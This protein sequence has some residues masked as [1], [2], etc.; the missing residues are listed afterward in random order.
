MRQEKQI[1]AETRLIRLS[2]WL[3]RQPLDPQFN[4]KMEAAEAFKKR[5]AA[6]VSSENAGEVAPTFHQATTV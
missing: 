2:W 3:R 1:T 4:V 6:W 5:L